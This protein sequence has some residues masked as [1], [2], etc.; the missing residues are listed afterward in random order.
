M[1]VSVGSRVRR[2]VVAEYE[3]VLSNAARRAVWGIRTVEER[4]DL[5]DCLGSELFQGPNVNS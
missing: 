4:N 3:V 2:P 1:F 5:A